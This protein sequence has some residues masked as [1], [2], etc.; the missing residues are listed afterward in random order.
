MNLYWNKALLIWGCLAKISKTISKDLRVSTV[1]IIHTGNLNNFN[2]QSTL[3]LLKNGILKIISNSEHKPS[4]D[5]IK[6]LK[7]TVWNLVDKNSCKIIYSTKIISLSI[8]CLLTKIMMKSLI[9][10]L[11]F[12]TKNLPSNFSLSMKKINNKNNKKISMNHINQINKC[13]REQ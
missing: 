11:L 5:P 6:Y 7:L 4:Q 10:N 8:T 12:P 9:M 3:L 2:T 13:K 1:T